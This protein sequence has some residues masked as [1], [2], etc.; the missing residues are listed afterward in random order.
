MREVRVR[1]G[2]PCGAT[3]EAAK[4]IVGLEAEEALSRIGL[5]TQFHCV[6]DPSAWDPLWGKSP[7]HFAADVHMAALGKVLSRLKNHSPPCGCDP[8]SRFRT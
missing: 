5:E 7:I 4:R 1:R 6:A 8:G 3:W 2:A